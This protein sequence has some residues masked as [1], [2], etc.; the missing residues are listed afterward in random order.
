VSTLLFFIIIESYLLTFNIF[1]I[2]R[3]SSSSKTEDLPELDI[4]QT[5]SLRALTIF[6]KEYSSV[7]QADN[8]RSL[9]TPQ[10]F[11]IYSV[12]I[13]PFSITSS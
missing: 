5:S 12:S 13:S 10:L 8:F 4:V 1:I 3:K 9:W 2:N 11:I 7:E 6:K